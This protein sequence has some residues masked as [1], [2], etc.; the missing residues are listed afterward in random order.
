M[1]FTGWAQF[2]RSQTGSQVQVDLDKTLISEVSQLVSM[3]EG[4]VA[5]R[6]GAQT[7]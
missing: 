4:E 3:L 6:T 2:G 5:S 1:Y 7:I